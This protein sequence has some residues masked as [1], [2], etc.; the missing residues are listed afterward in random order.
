MSK[1]RVLMEQSTN[2]T[3]AAIQRHKHCWRKQIAMRT[4]N[5]FIRTFR[6]LVSALL[7][8]SNFHLTCSVGIS[9]TLLVGLVCNTALFQHFVVKS[10]QTERGWTQ[11]LNAAPSQSAESERSISI[12]SVV[13]YEYSN[14]DNSLS[15]SRSCVT[16]KLSDC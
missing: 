4:D 15:L 14:W 8:L 13:R 7:L 3:M 16:A 9:D 11:M 2:S 10:L 12:Y 6:T 5:G 1:M